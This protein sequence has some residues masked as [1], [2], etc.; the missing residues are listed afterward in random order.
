MTNYAPKTEGNVSTPRPQ[1]PPVV[2][3]GLPVYN[4][5]RTIDRCVESVLKQSYRNFTLVISDNNSTDGTRER[6]RT[7][8]KQD[9]RIQ[10][11]EQKQTIGLSRNHFIPL[12]ASKAKYF[13]WLCADDYLEHDHLSTLIEL[14]DARPGATLAASGVKHVTEDNSYIEAIQFFG[15]DNPEELAT[16]QLVRRLVTARNDY[17]RMK[18]CRL[19]FGMYD[20]QKLQ[21]LFNGRED[22]FLIGDRILPAL[23]AL[24]GS[25]A[26]TSD[27]TYVKSI[28]KIS[29]SVRYAGDEMA[30]HSTS[31][32]RQLI[33]NYTSSLITADTISVEKKLLYLFIPIQLIYTSTTKSVM[34]IIGKARIIVSKH[35]LMRFRSIGQR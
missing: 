14:L 24:S 23:V 6:L 13:C 29:Y 8:E 30:S 22:F 33:K 28:R 25:V 17:K 12:Q 10:L 7:F 9:T 18:Y 26:Y 21:Q 15:K 4:E 1:V 3:I 20:R 32:I 19:I 34:K 16:H 35:V 27:I 2:T 11:L 5:E 31:N